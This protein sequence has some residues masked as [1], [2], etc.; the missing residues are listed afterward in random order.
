MVTERFGTM[1]SFQFGFDLDEGQKDSKEDSSSTKDYVTGSTSVQDNHTDMEIDEQNDPN[2]N[3]NSKTP[4]VPLRVWN[5][6]EWKSCKRSSI[7]NTKDLIMFDTIAIGSSSVSPLKK[8]NGHNNTMTEKKSAKEGGESLLFDSH[9][10]NKIEEKQTDLIPG[11]YEGGAK[12]WECSLDLCQYITEQL[13]KESL[14]EMDSNILL[15]NSMSTSGIKIW[16]MGCGHGLPACL[17]LRYAIH[18]RLRINQILFSDYN[19]FVLRQ[20]TCNNILLN[21]H[22]QTTKNQDIDTDQTNLFNNILLASGDWMD[23]SYSLQ[24][25]T[26][27]GENH[28]K[29]DSND[30]FQIILA[31]ETTYTPRT[32][33]ETAYLISRH[34]CPITGV[35]LIASK[36][37]YFGVGGGTDSFISAVNKF[38]ELTV[39]LLKEYDSGKAN[40]RDLLQVT[41]KRIDVIHQK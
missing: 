40:I 12:V 2:D 18:N 7:V 37:F 4:F 35:A 26:T 30:K 34:L 29:N 23:L 38:P 15:K 8:V 25:S 36:R 32:A 22:K 33:R 21:S 31:A 24:K 19:D 9:I 28:Q 20:I 41:Y 17:L 39:T 13:E 14:S 27:M 6:T 5:M 3:P 1:A 11:E 16:E 10:A